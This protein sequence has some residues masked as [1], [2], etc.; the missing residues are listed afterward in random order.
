MSFVGND[1]TRMRA[2]ESI[3]VAMALTGGAT[4]VADIYEPTEAELEFGGARGVE[5]MAK[6]ISWNDFSF[7]VQA[8]ETTAD[9]SLADTSSYEDFGQLNYGGNISM[10]Y[11]YDYNDPTNVYS[12]AYDMTKAPWTKL[13]VVMRVDGD[14]DVNDAFEDGDFVHAARTISDAETNEVAGSDSIRRTINLLPQGG[15]APYTIVGDHTITAVE[16]AN[17]WEAGKKARLRGI[18]QD[19]DYTAALTFTSSDSTV[20]DI[21]SDGSYE[22]TGTASD[23]ATI[24]ISDEGAGT[25]TTVAVTVT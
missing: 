11:P 24:T 15:V 6:A 14:K 4:G 9:P 10:Y 25:S 23:T 21:S 17:A 7:G 13:D 22:V 5:N 20:V 18:V 2:D 12:N 16:P 8:S 1:Y 19:R 3:G